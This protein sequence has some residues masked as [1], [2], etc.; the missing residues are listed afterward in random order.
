MAPKLKF[1]AFTMDLEA[2][3]AGALDHK[4]GLFRDITKIE[5]LLYTLNKF[6]VKVTVFTVG[7][8]F[9]LFPNVIRLFEKYGCEFE[10][11]SYS[12]NFD[13]S[14]SESEI[15]KCR[16]AYLNYFQK[17]PKGYRAPRGKISDAGIMALEKK[18]FLYDSSIFPSYFPNPFRYLFCNRDIHYYKGSHI[19]EIPF[20]SLSPL[21]LTLSI[22]YIK[23]FGLNFFKKLS[24]P[25]VVCFDSH[26]HDFFI[27]RESFDRLPLKWRLIYSRNKYRGLELCMNYLE[28][29][30]QKG[31]KFCYMSE[32]YYSHKK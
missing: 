9:S 15:E 4:Y 23:L 18:G 11:H 19:M 5:E 14:D 31:Y 12:H 16:A 7:E 28:H 21:R 30:K 6:G 10:A 20:T 22:S 24:L 1:F 8:I 13:T 26:L 29:V 2:D 27:I 25:D 32:I 17:Y 3:Y